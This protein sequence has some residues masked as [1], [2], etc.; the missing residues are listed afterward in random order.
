MGHTNVFK[1]KFR[2]LDNIKNRKKLF[3]QKADKTATIRGVYEQK[4]IQD[5]EQYRKTR[6]AS[7]PVSPKLTG[8]LSTGT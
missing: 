8:N 2:K 5:Q 3:G 4:R 6:K 7:A 1:T